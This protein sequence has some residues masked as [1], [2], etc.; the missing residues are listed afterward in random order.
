LETK[1]NRTARIAL[2]VYS[3]FDCPY[4]AKFART[5]LPEIE[6]EYL[7]TGKVL[8]GFRQYP[9]QSSHPL[10]MNAA[11][12]ALCAARQDRFWQMHDRLFD[13][14]RG[15]ASVENLTLWAEPLGIAPG[16]FSACLREPGVADQ[17]EADLAEGKR[18][19]VSGTPAF[20]A[21]EVRRNLIYATE[22]ISGAQEFSSCRAVLDKL[23]AASSQ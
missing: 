8:L 20:L 13:K 5:T 17:I 15:P 22:R 23:L 3:D 9:I 16:P 14:P 10:A 11:S 4:C 19:G 18:T 2:V 7:A 6:K 12:A 1:G 21:G